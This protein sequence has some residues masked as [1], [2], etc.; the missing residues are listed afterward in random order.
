MQNAGIACILERRAQNAGVTP[1]PRSNSRSPRYCSPSCQSIALHSASM[2][3][4]DAE[5][6]RL[7]DEQMERLLPAATKLLQATKRASHKVRKLGQP[8]GVRR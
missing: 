2:G 6:R 7:Q 3:T 8:S 4:G 5:G 1:Q